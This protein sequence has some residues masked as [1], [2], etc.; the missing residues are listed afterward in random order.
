M[1]HYPK[2]PH[3]V[4]P[5]TNAQSAVDAGS[6]HPVPP[7]LPG[8]VRLPGAR[9]YF[10]GVA[11]HRDPAWP[12]AHRLRWRDDLP[13]EYGIV[14]NEREMLSVVAGGFARHIGN[15]FQAILGQI[16]LIRL[17]AGIIPAAERHLVHIEGTIRYG[18]NLVCHLLA[19]TGRGIFCD[20]PFVSSQSKTGRPIGCGFDR[21]RFRSLPF[22][23]LDACCRAHASGRPNIAAA[24]RRLAMEF[25]R[26]FARIGGSLDA[27]DGL[28]ITPAVRTEAMR[29]ITGVG[30]RIVKEIA[31]FAGIGERV[32]P[33]TGECP[34][35]VN[36]VVGRYM[37]RRCRHSVPVRVTIRL[38]PFAPGAAA[39]APII[40]EVFAAVV[41]NALEAMSEGGVLWVETRR[42][43]GFHRD[44][45]LRETGPGA[46]L[47]VQD[48]GTGISPEDLNKI[49]VP[50]YTRRGGGGHLGLGLP[51]AYGR[52][53]AV[54]GKMD[55]AS[56]RRH[57]TTV[58]I[59]IPCAPLPDRSASHFLLPADRGNGKVRA[60][61][62]VC[63]W[64][65]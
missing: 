44:V 23:H 22:Y 47:I 33:E 11:A 8:D 51:G 31:F 1:H 28:A 18:S 12:G 42:I 32:A 56:E 16:G 14:E 24:S 41:D 40:E 17:D 61:A 20:A 30:S 38:D 19:L 55:V 21:E 34:T 54:G 52:I 5:E 43:T 48:A 59:T 46:E 10:S 27:L 7:G 49:C 35:D 25:R 65:A 6:F 64:V 58:R 29:R 13:G 37:K 39:P 26:L 45:E 3:T 57:G 53:R 63:H 50:F 15:L 2:A 36:R 9:F 60:D 4:Y 62:A